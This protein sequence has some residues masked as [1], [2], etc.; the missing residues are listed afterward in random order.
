MNGSS[1]L[2]SR[3][4]DPAVCHEDPAQPPLHFHH[5][6]FVII[7]LSCMWHELHL[8]IQFAHLEHPVSLLYI[9]PYSIYFV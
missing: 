6:G 7:L 4:E 5:F 3:S 2:P 8:E 1:V 9:N